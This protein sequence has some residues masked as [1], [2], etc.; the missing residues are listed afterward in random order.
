MI[1]GWDGIA[2]GPRPLEPCL[3]PGSVFF[4]EADAPP[5]V[6]PPPVGTCTAHGFGECLIGAWPQPVPGRSES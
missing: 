5:T 4:V 2:F 3:P 6:P 1:G